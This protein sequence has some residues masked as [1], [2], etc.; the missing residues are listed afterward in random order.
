MGK[1]LAKH[2]V[3]HE[4]GWIIKS[5]G[6]PAAKHAQVYATKRDAI[7]SARSLAKKRGTIL[8]I[9]GRDGRIEDV[10]TYERVPTR[11][12]LLPH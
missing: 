5:E 7:I 6:R 4:D 3:P 10:D 11:R 1:A 2:V 8:V 12:K 9:H